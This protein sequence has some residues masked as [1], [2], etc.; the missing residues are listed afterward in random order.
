[1]ES[2]RS[3]RIR[4][5]QSGEEGRVAEITRACPEA[6]QWSADAYR[7]FVSAESSGLAAQVI[8]VVEAQGGLAGFIVLR[9]A[10]GELE[11]LNLGIAPE[12]RRQRAGSDLLRAAFAWAQEYRCREAFCEVRESNARAQA[13][14]AAHGFARKG[15]RTGYYAQPAEDALILHRYLAG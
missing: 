6:A 15:R 8:F 11:I 4:P 12:M 14:Y 5:L 3:I 9:S 10:S 13:F 7:S 1:M 2:P